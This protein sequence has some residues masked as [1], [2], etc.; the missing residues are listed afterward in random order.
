ME[1][2]RGVGGG[3]FFCRDGQGMD[4]KKRINEK[5]LSCLLVFSG[6]DRDFFYGDCRQG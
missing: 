6:R 3:A 5:S 2:G 4:F 1:L